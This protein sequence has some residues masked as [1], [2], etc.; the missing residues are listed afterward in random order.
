[1]RMMIL[2]VNRRVE[3]PKNRV[4]FLE[5][6]RLMFDTGIVF[7]DELKDGRRTSLKSNK[8]FYKT[9]SR[10]L[11]MMVVLYTFQ[12]NISVREIG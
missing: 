3:V 11:R 1:M 12:V 10:L 2:Q 6:V 5:F 9:I 8:Y 4:S 7:E